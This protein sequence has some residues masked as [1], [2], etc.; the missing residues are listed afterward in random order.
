M[1]CPNCGREFYA[2]N[3][4]EIEWEMG[5]YYD[6]VIGICPNCEHKFFWTEVYVFDHIE[7]IEDNTE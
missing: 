2:T 4:I 3:T 7:D 6:T 1:I 5:K